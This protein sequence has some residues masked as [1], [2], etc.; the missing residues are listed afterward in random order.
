MSSSTI[1]NQIVFETLKFSETTFMGHEDVIVLF[2]LIFLFVSVYFLLFLF[3]RMSIWTCMY[4]C[5]PCM[6]TKR[7]H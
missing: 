5:A 1:L 3:V 4:E 2:S 7:G 6:E